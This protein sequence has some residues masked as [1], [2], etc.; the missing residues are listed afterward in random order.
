MEARYIAAAVVLLALVAAVRLFAKL[1]RT[2]YANTAL[3]IELAQREFDLRRME[4]AHRERLHDARSVLAGL[5]GGITVLTRKASSDRRDLQRM[6]VAELDRLQFLLD[7]AAPEAITDFELGRAL[8]PVLLAHRLNDEDIHCDLDA[9][10]VRGRPHATAAVLDN[11]LRNVRTHAPGA[12]VSI[13]MSV[14]EDSVVITVGDDGPGIPRSECLDVLRPGVRGS[15]ARG[16][17]SGLGLHSAASTMAKQHGY[18]RVDRGIAGGTT[19]TFALPLSP[20]AAVPLGRPRSVARL[21]EA[22]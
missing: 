4:L 18:L 12:E 5:A 10:T 17:G 16:A 19:V 20:P 13:G 22:S 3:Q 21:T 2:A 7:P 8:E 9:V 1:R 15:T 11:I 6:L 14:D